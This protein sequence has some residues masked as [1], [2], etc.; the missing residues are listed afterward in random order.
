[1]AAQPKMVMHVDRYD[2]QVDM[3]SLQEWESI[4][5]DP[6]FKE[7]YTVAKGI[8]QVYGSKK[9]VTYNAEEEMFIVIY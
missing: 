8:D 4:K 1:M 2:G 9:V 7:A 5:G 3:I 6:D